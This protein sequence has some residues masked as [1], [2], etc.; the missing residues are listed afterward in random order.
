MVPRS[1]IT[2]VYGRSVVG[3]GYKPTS[4][5]SPACFVF[6]DPL[7]SRRIHSAQRTAKLW[8]MA[9]LW[10]RAGILFQLFLSRSVADPLFVAMSIC[11]RGVDEKCFVPQPSFSEA[12]RCLSANS[13]QFPMYVRPGWVFRDSPKSRPK[14]RA[15][16]DWEHADELEFKRDS[17]FQIHP[18]RIWLWLWVNIKT[19]HSTLLFISKLLCWNMAP[20]LTTQIMQY[21][22]KL[23]GSMSKD[24]R[25]PT[26][27]FLGKIFGPTSSFAHS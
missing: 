24:L 8:S 12:S 4:N 7:I 16:C 21:W 20:V 1:Q 14:M 25:T 2:D 11:K 9:L 27:P 26:S 23:S 22:D 17:N 10:Q 5:W 13:R 19:I 18:M 6:V 15:V 3:W